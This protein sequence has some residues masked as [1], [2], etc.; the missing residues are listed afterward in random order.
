MQFPTTWSFDLD[1]R[2]TH[3]S[4]TSTADGTGPTFA[5]PTSVDQAVA[6]FD[7]THATPPEVS[8]LLEVAH[9]LLRTSVVHYEFAP[10]AAEK[11]LQALERG[12]RLRFGAPDGVNFKNLIDRVE[13][14]GLLGSDDLDLLDTAR[15]VRNM[16]AHPTTAA[17]LPLVTVTGMVRNSH[18]LI[19]ALFPDP[20]SDLKAPPAS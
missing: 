11:S 14:E 20:W 7:R 18:R 1:P 13:K 2:A 6:L 19:A 17:A 10:I 15:R 12:L 8:S 3:M 5:T 9:K 4:L 16:F